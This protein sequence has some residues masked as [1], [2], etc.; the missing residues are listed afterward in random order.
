M[1]STTSGVASI[2]YSGRC[3]FGMTLLKN[4]TMLVYGGQTNR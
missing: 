4:G 1:N 3:V 2:E